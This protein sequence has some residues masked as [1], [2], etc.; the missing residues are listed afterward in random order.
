MHTSP[1]SPPTPHKQALIEHVAAQRW[2]PALR[3]G[4]ALHR[5]SP[6][7]AG[8]RF[9]TAS[10]CAALGLRTPGERLL[11]GLPPAAAADPRIAQLLRRLGTLRDTRQPPAER[12]ER[13]R[14]ALAS[15]G[16]PLVPPEA[17]GAFLAEDAAWT[18]CEGTDGNVVGLPPPSA[19]PL[20]LA[21]AHD[22]RGPADAAPP[23]Q[24]SRAGIGPTIVLAGLGPPW[25]LPRTAAFVRDS[26]GHR[27]PVHIVEP[28][29]TT[30]LRALAAVDLAADLAALSPRWHVGPGPVE[31][32]AAALAERLHHRAHATLLTSLPPEATE[33][34]VTVLAGRLAALEARREHETAALRAALLGGAALRA[35][36]SSSASFAEDPP[37]PPGS[38]RVLIFTHRHSTFVRHSSAD[39]A[40]AFRRLGHAARVVEEADDHSVLTA[41]LMLREVVD[42]KPDLIATINYTRDLLKPLADVPIPW[43]C[44]V[45]DKMPHLVTAPQRP[46]GELDFGAGHAFPEMFERGV[47]HPDRFVPFPVAVDPEKFHAG[48]ADPALLERFACDLAFVSNHGEHPRAMHDRLVREASADWPDAE[49]TLA[50]IYDAVAAGLA[51]GDLDAGP[52]H[53]AAKIIERAVETA[54]LRAAGVDVERLADFY[55]WPVAERMLRHRTLEEASELCRRR[56]WTLRIFGRNWETHPTL[57]AH[58]APPLDHGEELR[59]C[60]QAARAHLH[61]SI[62]APV[63][64]RVMECA[65]SGGL[66]LIRF[67]PSHLSSLAEVVAREGPWHATAPEAP[68]DHWRLHQP[69]QLISLRDDRS[70]AAVQATDHAAYLR[71][72]RLRATMGLPKLNIQWQDWLWFDA[73]HADAFSRERPRVAGDAHLTRLVPE[74]AEVCF[75]T[76]EQ[77]AA[78]LDRAAQRPE[79]RAN[80]SRMIAR[81]VDEHF[82]TDALAR[83]VVRMVTP[84][85]AARPDVPRP[86]VAA[87]AAAAMPAA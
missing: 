46:A 73:T 6:A 66:P 4:L 62:F 83:A 33:P 86:P 7:D 39:I 17:V 43:L 84:T 24:R 79:W 68:A 65:R 87:A 59:A 16:A 49:R 74:P 26:A 22:A 20:H 85:L 48:P 30:L 78:L 58:A 47:L 57:A 21:W 77:L 38:L 67:L 44:I 25:Q 19:A 61:I 51:A 71:F 23:A 41:G 50:P 72:L 37:A 69:Y 60:Y 35:T 15:T 36:V 18:W 32:A 31:S 75:R 70:T 56:G 52:A 10:A 2:W 76:P 63:H 54:P 28:D 55:V 53:W 14:A 8:V 1:I 81:R 34:W 40:S 11:E 27:S 5:A 82:T 80:V 3:L 13:V 9:L 29:T 64:Q 42:Y 12:A 45:Q